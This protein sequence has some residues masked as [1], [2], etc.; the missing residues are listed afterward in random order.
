MVYL[1][2]AT[3]QTKLKSR[4][5]AARKPKLSSF[6]LSDKEEGDADFTD[7]QAEEEQEAVDKAM[8]MAA[9]T[10]SGN[11][12]GTRKVA[13]DVFTMMESP[14]YHMTSPPLKGAEESR[15]MFISIGDAVT[16][17]NVGL[18]RASPPSSNDPVVF[19]KVCET[20]PLTA[21]CAT[22]KPAPPSTSST[23]TTVPAEYPSHHGIWG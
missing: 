4:A 14:G 2:G 7:S 16:N 23:V 20:P 12:K 5:K 21:K 9:H 1:S 19:K 6:I 3:I 10:R 18:K 13:F 15:G 22:P 8:P 11:S 17:I